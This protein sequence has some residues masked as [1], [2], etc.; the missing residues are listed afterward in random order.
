M[1]GAKE[2]A[3]GCHETPKTPTQQTHLSVHKVT[4][5]LLKSEQLTLE[6]HAFSNPLYGET[7][8]DDEA[9]CIEPDEPSHLPQV[10]SANEYPRQGH[11]VPLQVVDLILLAIVGDKGAVRH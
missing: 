5:S 7:H 4:D 2:L 6:L 8:V 10:S 3:T 9:D 1:W 11:L